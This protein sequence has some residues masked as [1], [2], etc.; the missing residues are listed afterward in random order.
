MTNFHRFT[1]PTWY[2]YAT[3]PPGGSATQPGNKDYDRINIIS[4]GTGTGGSAPVDGVAAGGANP[5]TY[6]VSFGEDAYSQAVN[7]GLAA[8]AQNT[9]WLDDVIHRDL[10]VPSY[11]DK[12]GTGATSFTLPSMTYL[13]PAGTT[14]DADGIEPFIL[15]VDADGNE[16]VHQATNEKIRVT[17]ITGYATSPSTPFATVVITCNLNHPIPN[18][19]NYRVLFAMRRSLV[20]ASEGAWVY[21][22]LGNLAKVNATEQTLLKLLHGNDLAWNAAWT[23][24]IYDLTLGGLNERYR[25]ATTVYNST[26]DGYTTFAADTPGSGASFERDG[27][28]MRGYSTNESIGGGSNIYTDP[29]NAI[30]ASYLQSPFAA[31]DVG[32]YVEGARHY[33]DLG[34]S[35]L[36]YSPGLSSFLYAA[37]RANLGGLTGPASLR[38]YITENAAVTGATVSGDLVVTLT[39]ADDHFWENGSGKTSIAVGVDLLEV[40]SPNWAG[41]ANKP[42]TCVITALDPANPKKATLR[43]LSGES[44][45]TLPGYSAGFTGTVNWTSPVFSVGEGGPEYY[46]ALH[47]GNTQP[48]RLRGLF[49]TTGTVLAQTDVTNIDPTP[50]SFFGAPTLLGAATSVVQWGEHVETVTT[51]QS[52]KYEARGTLLSDGGITAT[53]SS[54][55]LRASPGTVY[56][57]DVPGPVTVDLSAALAE[58]DTVF[59]DVQAPADITDI[60]LGADVVASGRKLEV[61]FHHRLSATQITNAAAWGTCLFEAPDDKYL[62]G[63]QGHL[64]HYTIF[65]PAYA[66]GTSKPLVSVRRYTP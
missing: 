21:P 44:L 46:D 36:R 4:G 23:S 30:W 63:I 19:V 50:A 60:T 47:P 8:L 15:I 66:V 5:G 18:A 12:I 9:D 43:A 33:T 16:I 31:G 45:S 7:R 39:G 1:D 11:S 28:S 6:F 52:A 2:G 64:D 25:R 26:G 27:I 56:V 58:Y 57:L 61:I 24:T 3:I 32:F 40:V 20:N 14:L 65:C 37:R 17:S 38:T 41:H 10:A 29:I 62:S 54:I 53:H 49:H 13:G 55:P 34:V 22:T 51:A 48:I 42:I 59:V 35:E